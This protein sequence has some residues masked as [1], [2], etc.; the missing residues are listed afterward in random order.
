[1]DQLLT[2]LI[3]PDQFLLLYLSYGKVVSLVQLVHLEL[4][5]LNQARVRFQHQFQFL[6]TLFELASQDWLSVNVHTLVIHD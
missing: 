6:N 3:Q 5:L 2:E 4:H 1:M